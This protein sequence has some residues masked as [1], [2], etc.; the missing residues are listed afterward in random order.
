MLKKQNLP[1]L[2]MLAMLAIH[3]KKKKKPAAYECKQLELTKP[4]VYNNIYNMG[5]HEK[6]AN[7]LFCSAKMAHPPTFSI[8]PI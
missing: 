7:V 3:K 5:A 4:H 1:L 8:L 2:A 6:K